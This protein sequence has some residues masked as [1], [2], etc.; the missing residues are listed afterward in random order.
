MDEVNLQKADL[1]KVELYHAILK[2]AV[3]DK[4]KLTKS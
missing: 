2:N 1:R 4:V 3:M